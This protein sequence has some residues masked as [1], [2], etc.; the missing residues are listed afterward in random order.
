ML[1]A[2]ILFSCEVIY[3]KA[4]FIIKV[5]REKESFDDFWKRSLL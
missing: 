2:V 1:S 3:G 5:Y 4:F